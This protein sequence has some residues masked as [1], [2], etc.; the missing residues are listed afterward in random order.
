MRRVI[1]ALEARELAWE[2]KRVW[3]AACAQPEAKRAKAQAKA[4]AVVGGWIGADAPPSPE[5]IRALYEV[6][7]G[8]AA[9]AS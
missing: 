5:R 4:A 3:E 8:M 7:L 2:V 9:A 1:P 6:P